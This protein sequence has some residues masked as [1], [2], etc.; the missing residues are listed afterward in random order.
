MIYKNATYVK[1]HFGECMTIAHKEPLIV[2]SHGKKNV[3]IVSY[4]EFLQL[5]AYED[6]YWGEKAKEFIKESQFLSPEESLEYLK[7]KLDAEN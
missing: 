4:E 7:D 3:V 5:Q 6:H 2:E 1:T